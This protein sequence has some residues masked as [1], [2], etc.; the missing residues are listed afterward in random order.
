MVNVFSKDC[1]INFLKEVADYFI[2]RIDSTEK[3]K[4]LFLLY[5][6]NNEEKANQ[7]VTKLPMIKE[8]LKADLDFFMLSDPAINSIDDVIYAYPGFK[9]IVCYR[10]AHIIFEVGLLFQARMISEIAHSLTGIDIHPAAKIDCPFFIDHGTGIVIGETAVVGKG[11]KLY[12][13]VTLGALSLSN[14]AKMK[15]IKRHPTIGD[16]VTIYS[17]A[18]ILGDI[19]IGEKT[20]IGANVFLTESVGENMKVILGK[21]ELVV[22]KKK[23]K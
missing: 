4:E 1:Y 10:I 6:D 7:V 11:V 18:S 20:T 21:P 14:G 13:G 9:A 8:Q 12:Q 3:I 15:G 17:C 2:G 16:Y 5:I 19:T 22:S 23:N